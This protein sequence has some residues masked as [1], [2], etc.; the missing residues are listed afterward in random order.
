MPLLDSKTLG[1]TRLGFADEKDLDAFVGAVE[2]SGHTES[3]PL[4]VHDPATGLL[5]RAHRRL[6]CGD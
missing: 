2:T 5:A 4:V 6:P 3:S 1:P